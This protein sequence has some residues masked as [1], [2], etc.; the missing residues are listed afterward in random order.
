MTTK[1]TPICP[2]CDGLNRR[3]FVRAV[4]GLA[5]AAPLVGL[6]GRALAAPSP[7]SA[8]E[9]AAARLFES[10]NDEQRTITCFA[11]DHPSRSKISANWAI[12]DRS[13][14]SLFDKDQQALCDE[15]FRGVTSPDGYE[16]F[17]KQM[18]EDA[19]GFSEYHV[20]LFGEPG[21][22]QFECV[23]TGR[24][25]TI[26]ADGDCVA[27]AA[28]GGP[29]VYGHGTGNGQGGLPGNVFF[30]QTQKAN[31][32][33]M[34]LD[35]TQREQALLATAPRESAVQLQGAQGTFPGVGVGGLSADQQALVRDVIKVILAPYRSEDVDEALA[36]LDAGGGMDKLHMAFYQNNDL[37]DDQV[38]DVWRLEGPTFV[39]HFRGAPHVHA[40]V[41]IAAL[42]A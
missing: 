23:M 11:V 24:H 18:D 15:I 37:G 14:G 13:I 19:G 38:W 25:L 27:G 9:S 8:A 36:V 26:R 41:N 10:L 33:F 21:S 31:E 3:D 1:P 42:K 35:G 2:D 20:A 17:Q 22:G 7:T 40:Y 29:I 34:A 4:G 39:W 28:F 32:V 12:T 5:V 30:Y 16:R 6:T